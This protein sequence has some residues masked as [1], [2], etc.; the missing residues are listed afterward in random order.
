[1]RIINLKA[2]NV[3][4]L[5]AVDI[6][7]EDDVIVVS[8]ANGAGKTSVLDCIWW[9]LGGKKAIPREPIRA[10]QERA[11]VMLDLGDLRVM[12]TITEKEAYLKVETAD[13]KKYSKPQE[14]LDELVGRFTFDPLEF[15]R[16][17]PPK[18]RDG[19][20]ELVGLKE[21][22][23]A[24]DERRKG[25]YEE[26]TVVNREA[27]K[28]EKV[29]ESMPSPKEG[30]PE[31]KTSIAEMSSRLEEAH[32]LIAANTRE[33]ECFER[34]QKDVNDL[35]ARLEALRNE[36]RQLEADAMK[37]ESKR[38]AQANLV[39]S[40]KDPP[41]ATIEDELEK[42]EAVN[43]DILAAKVYRG[44]EAEWKVKAKESASLS[45][46]LKAIDKEKV[47]LVAGAEFPVPGL[48]FSERGVRLNDVPLEQCA[49]S[50][51]LQVGLAIAMILNPT[52]R[53]CRITD[54]SLLDKRN[55]DVLR[56][57][58]QERDFQVWIER[59]DATGEVTVHIVDGEIA[60]MEEG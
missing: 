32:N 44:A 25:V 29:L 41:L 9:A 27:D 7:P 19:L 60:S 37:L 43:D 57:M 38:S 17:E 30:L 56:R 42:V 28:L 21:D 52:V 46:D 49:S 22:L 5:V 4:R 16:M 35:V 3:K 1:M 10:G 11:E 55:M 54:G 36:T 45:A 39:A 8:G 58:A 2:T 15:I 59:V 31:E 13:G 26:R 20:L 18:Q 34:L 51:Q 24:L 12:R 6:T 47:E 48:G 33:H 50:E 53:V 40:L 14:V 23:D